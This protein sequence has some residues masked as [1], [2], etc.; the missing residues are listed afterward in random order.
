MVLP[1]KQIALLDFV[2]RVVKAIFRYLTNNWWT[3]GDRLKAQQGPSKRQTASRGRKR[4]KVERVQTA[5]GG[6]KEGQSSLR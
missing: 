4:G 2:G 3:M 6:V 5:A 1:K